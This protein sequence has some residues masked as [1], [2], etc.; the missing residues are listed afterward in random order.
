M[1]K[2]LRTDDIRDKEEP[3]K[4]MGVFDRDWQLKEAHKVYFHDLYTEISRFL[5]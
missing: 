4:K 1:L 5:G 2:K 3:K